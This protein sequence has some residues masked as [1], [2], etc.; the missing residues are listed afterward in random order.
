MRVVIDT[1]VL[2]SAVLKDRT[3]EEVILFI[4]SRDDMEWLVTPEIM[5]EYREV[6]GRRKFGLPADILHQWFS[7][8]DVLTTTCSGVEGIE[9]PRDRKDA[10]FIACALAAKADYLIT[11]D[12]DF[13]EAQK[14]LT[15]T[16]LTVSQFK[17]LVCERLERP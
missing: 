8:L 16:I 2:V 1:N 15:T 12:R 9:F 6:L 17:R 4:A 5:T 14:L 13:S 3:P 7:M 10:K 11:G